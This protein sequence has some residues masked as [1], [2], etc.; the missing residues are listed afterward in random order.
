MEAIIE[1]S[2]SLGSN[3]SFLFLYVTQAHH[4][5]FLCLILK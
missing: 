3:P 5:T 1:M 4:F 2:S